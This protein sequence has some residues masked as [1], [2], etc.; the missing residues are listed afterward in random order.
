MNLLDKNK[1]YLVHCA[2][3]Y[4]SM[5]AV[6][7]LKKNGFKSVVNVRGGITKMIQVGV[8]TVLPEMA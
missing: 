1:S 6:S 4:R 5:M 7:L 2:G 8:P 3:G